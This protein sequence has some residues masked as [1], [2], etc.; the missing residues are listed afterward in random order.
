MDPPTAQLV[1]KT[2]PV[3]VNEAVFTEDVRIKIRSYRTRWG[4]VLVPTPRGGQWE[5][6]LEGRKGRLQE[7]FVGRYVQICSFFT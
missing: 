7:K 2:E 1:P 5:G 6:E 4:A 3:A